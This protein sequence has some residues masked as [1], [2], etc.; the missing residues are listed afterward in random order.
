MDFSQIASPARHPIHP[1]RGR[2]AYLRKLVVVRHA[3]E[4]CEFVSWDDDI[5]NIW[6]VRKAMF[7]TT[8][9]W[10]LTIIKP[11]IKPLLTIINHY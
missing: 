6:K 11:F 10:L 5:P 4:K 8:N 9:Q 3:S 1:P 2:T 7:Q